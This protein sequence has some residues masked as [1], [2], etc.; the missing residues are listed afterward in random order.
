MILGWMIYSI[1]FGA[2]CALAAHALE[3]AA[4]AVG[5]PSRWIW[6][7]AMLATVATSTIATFKYVGYA[8]TLIPRRQGATWLDRPVGNYIR[9]YD[10][11]SRWDPILSP[12]LWI[13]SALVAAVFAIAI[14]RL[15]QRRRAWLRT[16]VDGHS[17]LVSE[18][19]GPA[20]IGFIRSVIV[21][22]KWALAES[23]RVRSLI[24]AHELEHQRARDHLLSA[25][26]ILVTIVQPWNPAVWW[27]SRRLRLALEVDCDS[28][29]LRRGP[30]RRTY[31][32]LL[33]EAGSRA[34]GCRLA[35]P[36]FSSP[37]SSLEERLRV[38][39]AERRSGR[40]R[41][42]RLALVGGILIATA[43]FVP[44]PGALH[45]ILEGLGFA[46]ATGSHSMSHSATATH[47]AHH[48]APSIHSITISATY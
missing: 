20:I 14:L 21:V 8:N 25:L 39:T 42:A 38:I 35:M 6:L 7:S 31:G 30:D 44:E 29:V 45:C 22:P 23:E 33:L 5:T 46:R 27:L 40:M 1:V 37:L 11:L 48:S 17:V 9:Y 32:L 2:L 47:S 26:A 15:I 10:S 36:A 18:A 19:E 16:S 3:N 12:L 28:R 34:A 41:A 43:A 24:M 4:R 13:S